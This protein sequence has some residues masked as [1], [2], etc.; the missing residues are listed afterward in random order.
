MFTIKRKKGIKTDEE[1]VAK[2][3][4]NL[5]YGKFTR[6]IRLRLSLARA[7]ARTPQLLWCEAGYRSSHRACVLLNQEAHS[8]NSRIIIF[9]E[10]HYF[11]NWLVSM[12]CRVCAATIQ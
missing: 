7:R 6:C 5:L 2:N 3:P 10:H 4:N 8:W 9:T 11:I 12:W 1:S